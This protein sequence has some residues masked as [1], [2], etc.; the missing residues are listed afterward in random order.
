MRKYLSDRAKEQEGVING[1][2]SENIVHPPYMPVPSGVRFKMNEI[3]FGLCYN[4]III[5]LRITGEGI[6][7]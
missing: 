3:M 6:M 7:D 2:Q 4:N 1:I 5:V